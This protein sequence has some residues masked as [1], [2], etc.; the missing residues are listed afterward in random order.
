MRT[1]SRAE[2]LLSWCSSE[3]TAYSTFTQSADLCGMNN[4]TITLYS[5][6]VS[7]SASVQL[8]FSFGR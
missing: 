1:W 8:S 7:M 6:K 3:D 2:L 4:S 5:S